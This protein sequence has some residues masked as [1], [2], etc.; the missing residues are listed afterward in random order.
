MSVLQRSYLEQAAMPADA[1]QCNDQLSLE[2]A[3]VRV[4]GVE[5]EVHVRVASMPASY[6]SKQT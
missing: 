5:V 3:Q 2:N 4:S 1:S 6:W